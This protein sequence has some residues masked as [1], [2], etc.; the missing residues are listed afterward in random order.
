[1]N[2]YQEFDI[3]LNIGPK[4][5]IISVFDKKNNQIYQDTFVKDSFLPETDENI[6]NEFLDKNIFK[7]EKLTKIFV[8][9]IN[10]VVDSNLFKSVKVSTKRKSFGKKITLNEMKQMLHEIKEEVKENNLDSSIIHMLIENYD[11]DNKQLKDLDF[12]LSC[13]SLIMEIQF[14]FL[15]NF[16][17]R[18]LNVKFKHYQVEIDRILSANYV[19]NFN[20]QNGLTIN[21]TAL[22]IFNGENFNEVQIVPKNIN[23]MGFFE[24]FFDLFN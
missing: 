12:E 16:F 18:N 14:I 8:K 2:N 15:S 11:V 5:I 3:F 7:I 13:D 4:E 19:R 20:S 9:K 17:I 23:K 24:K 1:M 21:Q 22:K 6:L 10:L